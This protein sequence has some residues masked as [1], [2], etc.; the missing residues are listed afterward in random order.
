LRNLDDDNLP[1]PLYEDQSPEEMSW[2][3]VRGLDLA[4]LIRKGWKI[5][6]LIRHF[7]VDRMMILSKIRF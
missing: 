4:Y 5:D 3:E 2:D 6:T 7:N 1:L